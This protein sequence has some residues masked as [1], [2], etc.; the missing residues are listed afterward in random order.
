MWPV[1][2]TQPVIYYSIQVF[3]WYCKNPDP[4]NCKLVIQIFPYLAGT[5]DLETKFES[6]TTDKLI[7]YIDSDS[8]GLK[9]GRKSPSRYLFIFFVNLLFHQSKQQTTVSVSSTKVEYKAI[10]EVQKEVSLIF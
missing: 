5:L 8:V 1:V 9:D 4:I 2:Y 6:D 3:S 10:T 7:R